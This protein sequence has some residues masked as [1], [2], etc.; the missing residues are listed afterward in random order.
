MYRAMC[1][2]VRFTPTFFLIISAT[3]LLPSS[4]RCAQTFEATICHLEC[5]FWCSAALDLPPALAPF[6][7]PE[8]VSA[9]PSKRNRQ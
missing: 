4:G 9:A 2:E 3:A 5:S 6:R 1:F 8:P 7:A